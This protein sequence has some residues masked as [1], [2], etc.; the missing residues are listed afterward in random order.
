MGHVSHISPRVTEWLDIQARRGKFKS[1]LMPFCEELVKKKLKDMNAAS[2]NYSDIDKYIILRHLM[3]SPSLKYVSNETLHEIKKNGLEF[4]KKD[5]TLAWLEDYKKIRSLAKRELSFYEAA[6]TSFSNVS[7]LA[8]AFKNIANTSA[9]PDIKLRAAY[10][11]LRNAKVAGMRKINTEL[12][13]SAEFKKKLK[14]FK[15]LQKSVSTPRRKTTQSEIDEVYKLQRELYELNT[16]FGMD[17][18]Y[19]VE[20]HGKFY[21]DPQMKKLIENVSLKSG[22]IKAYSGVG[23]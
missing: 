8:K 21:F 18:F 20:W 17:A 19:A 9:Y 12:K 4:S 11:Y 6:D 15:E 14:R 2:N 7:K 22:S 3:K 16:K 10:G 13:E 5:T 1:Q 23:F